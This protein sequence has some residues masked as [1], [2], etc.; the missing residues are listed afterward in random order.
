MNSAQLEA[1]TGKACQWLRWPTAWA[2]L[3][4]FEAVSLVFGLKIIGSFGVAYFSF[5]LFS[6]FSSSFSVDVALS[7]SAQR[8]YRQQQPS[9]LLT[10]TLCLQELREA[11]KISFQSQWYVFLVFVSSFHK[12]INL[13]VPFLGLIHNPYH[14]TEQVGSIHLNVWTT[15]LNGKTDYIFQTTSDVALETF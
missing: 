10:L 2:G 9:P 6:F 14:T 3:R 11:M 4:I 7:K 8:L 15:L 1:D 5:Q 12:L 13:N